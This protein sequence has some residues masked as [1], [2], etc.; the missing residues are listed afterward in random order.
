MLS[1]SFYTPLNK[2][3][4]ENFLQYIWTFMSPKRGLN[5]HY[6]IQNIFLF[7]YLVL[8]VVFSPEWGEYLQA[9]PVGLV[10]MAPDAI[11]A[12]QHGGVTDLAAVVGL[13]HVLILDTSDW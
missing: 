11:E 10:D 12:E 5:L 2:I 6:R 8:N 13:F 9:E 7:I 3:V 1:A 4:L